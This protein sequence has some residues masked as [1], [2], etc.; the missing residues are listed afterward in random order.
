MPFFK[1][2][3]RGRDSNPRP[4]AYETD[5]LPTATT[6]KFLMNKQSTLFSPH[7]KCSFLNFRKDFIQ[8]SLGIFGRKPSHPIYEIFSVLVPDATC[9]EFHIV[10][11]YAPPSGLEP[12]PFSLTV[13]CSQSYLELRRNIIS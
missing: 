10:Y 11:F 7:Q 8:F 9:Y 2:E 6:P 1:I 4:S 5:E 13:S 12:L 3:F